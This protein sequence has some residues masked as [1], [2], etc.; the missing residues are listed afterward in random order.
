MDDFDLDS[1]LDR[2]A[3]EEEKQNVSDGAKVKIESARQSL[4]P[5]SGSGG[6]IWGAGLRDIFAGD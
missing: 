6:D 2:Y 3:P 1:F 5:N 4:K